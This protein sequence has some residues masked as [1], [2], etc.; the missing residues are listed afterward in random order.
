[1][2]ERKPKV[3]IVVPVYNVER[4]IKRCVQSLLNQT[5]K[6]IE[7]ILVDDGSPDKSPQICDE[8][9][10]KDNRIIVVHK[11]NGGLGSAR[12]A[13]VKIATGEYITFC[14]SD[15]FVSPNT[16][17]NVYEEC[18]KIDLDVCFFQHCRYTSI[19]VCFSE[20]KKGKK[21]SFLSS[22]AIKDLYLKLLSGKQQMSVCMA[23]IRRSIIEE[24][25]ISCPSER[26]VASEDLLYMMDIVS[27]SKKAVKL[28]NVYYYYYINPA[29][30]S[31]TWNEQKH[32]RCLNLLRV[33]RDK[34]H[35][36]D[37]RRVG[38]AY[39]LQILRIFKVRY[40]FTSINKSKSINEKIRII[41]D[42]YNSVFAKYLIEH[43]SR[44]D[45]SSSDSF[46]FICT[47]Y[48]LSLLLLV[49]YNL[50]YSRWLN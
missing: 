13:G 11:V 28:P 37:D 3:S 50:R 19:D 23:L 1:M 49:F 24:N 21:E 39:A 15:D 22:D 33:V 9:A 45:F 14:D 18:R 40:K 20:A 29:S 36:I 47:K 42:T 4:Y 34:I 46:I 35:S 48:K 10:S 2:M 7:V 12:N 17:Y 25:N 32:Q 26:D 44:S 8:Y 6:E 31:T 41:S 16:Y 27:H 38:G 5:L 30:L 43:V